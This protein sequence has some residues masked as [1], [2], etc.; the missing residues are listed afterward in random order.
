MIDLTFTRGRTLQATVSVFDQDVAVSIAGGLLT[1][2]M[3]LGATRITK[4]TA[5]GDIV[6]GPGLGQA[7]VK[8]LPA[9]TSALANAPAVWDYDLSIV[10]PNTDQF[11]LMRGRIQ[12]FAQ[13]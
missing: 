10:M 6:A 9:D 13:V 7:I 12:M 1:F 2:N 8:I 4:T 5:N 11:T 3:V